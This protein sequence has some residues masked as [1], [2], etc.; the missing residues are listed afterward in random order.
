M[1]EKDPDPKLDSIGDLKDR[2]AETWQLLLGIGQATSLIPEVPTANV[3]SVS[4]SLITG[5]LGAGKT[6]LLNALLTE[7]HGARIAVLVNDFGSINIDASLIRQSTVNSIDLTNGCVCCTLANGLVRTLADLVSRDEPPDEILLEAS[8]ISDPQGIIQIALCN[9]ALRLNGIVCV[10]DADAV[11]GNLDNTSLRLTIE[12]QVSAADLVILNKTDIAD[13]PKLIAARQWLGQRAAKA[14]IVETVY[15]RVPAAVIFGFP[16]KP[17]FAPHETQDNHIA[18]FE[19]FSFFSEALIDETRICALAASLP[20]GVLRA[21]GILRLA[22]DP[23]R[24]AVLQVTAGRWSLQ[25]GKELSASRSSEIVA[26]GLKG[27]ID[28]E[29]LRNRFDS[30][31]A[32]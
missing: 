8:G 10:V 21:K 23:S 25:K 6:T 32:P 12:R 17:H 27:M 16:A 31:K 24:Q 5:F 1:A 13:A 22:S 26:I 30:C 7:R 9:S 29:Q 3:Q 11:T 28:I 19:S 15:A 2:M 4:F 14:R 20:D 18:A